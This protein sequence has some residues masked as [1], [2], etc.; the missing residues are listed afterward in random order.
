MKK[1]LLLACAALFFTINSFAQT[2]GTIWGLKRVCVGSTTYVYDSVLSG[3]GTFTCSPMG[4]VSV[5]TTSSCCG[6]YSGAITGLTAGVVS[7]YFYSGSFVDSMVFTVD[8]TPTAISGVSSLCVGTSTTF[9]DGVAG[10]VWSVGGGHA[11]ISSATGVLT[12][13]SPGIE[14][15]TYTLPGGCSRTTTT[16]V[17]GT[18]V[19]PIIA[20]VKSLCIGTTL[21][22]TDMSASGTWTSSMGSVATVAAS[23][24]LNGVVTGV[25]AGNALITYSLGAC[26]GWDT[27]RITVNG[28][29]S[30][31][32]ISGSSSVYV[33][34][35]VALTDPIPGGI[36]GSSNPSIA[37]IS[38]SGVVTGVAAGSVTITYA[39]TGC[40][41]TALTT[42]GITVSAVNGISGHVVF[43]SGSFYGNVKVWLITYNSSTFDLQAQDSTT[44]YCSGSSVYYQFLGTATGTYRIKAATDDTAYGTSGYIPTYRPNVPYWSSADTINHIFGTS[45]INKDDTMNM[46]TITTGPGFVGGNVTMGANKGTSTIPAVGL[47]MFVQNAT[48][49]A[50]LQSVRTDASGN[51]SFSNLPAGIYTV[52]PELLN[53]A[54]TSYPS[55][56]ITAGAP[57]MTAANFIQH[58]L[59]KTI[60]PVPSSTSNVLPSVSSVSVFPNPSN[61]KMTIQWAEVANETGHVTISDLTGREVFKTNIDMTAG[62]GAQKLDLSGLTNGLYMISVKSASINYNNK[63]QVQH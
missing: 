13:T 42:A 52:R 33:G 50:I 26:A 54:A 22:L 36:W 63:I 30:A 56:N 58:T 10:G 37:S 62:S 12:G 21:T 38:S 20:P 5:T 24:T 57:S 19:S 59:S 51:Y 34:S 28:V 7:I 2:T 32:T 16:N 23:G 3:V 55:I 48:T 25:A 9:T 35:T 4:I 49:H 61:G 41:G 31:G 29:T 15:I 39:V 14:A 44:V 17:T 45:D 11:T 1:L 8:P 60:K 43:P 46:G 53:Y 47:L 40:T 27:V 18:A 6:A